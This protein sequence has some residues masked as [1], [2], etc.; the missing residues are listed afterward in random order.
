MGHITYGDT[1]SIVELVYYLPLL[2]ATLFVAWKHRATSF[3]WFI[4]VSF[5]LIRI[6][7]ACARIDTIDHPDSDTA[8]TMAFI[9]SIFGL[10]PLLMAT[11]G[12]LSR[13]FYQV[14]AEPWNKIYGGHA[15]TLLVHIPAMVAVVLCIVGATQVHEA[16]DIPNQ[17]TVKAGIVIFAVVFVLVAGFSVLAWV[18]KINTGEGEG[19]LIGAVLLTVPFLAVRLLYSL[20]SV[21]DSGSSTFNL[22][23]GSQTA[24]LCMAVL[25]EMLVVAILVAAG[26]KLSQQ[27]LRQQRYTG[28][29]ATQKR[30]L[31]AVHAQG[32]EGKPSDAVEQQC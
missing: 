25:E 5:C 1:I 31:D 21:F 14:R 3:A 9:C 18:A 24:A 6:I 8:Y 10:S 29:G 27:V 13:A 23:H 4:L 26:L 15:M 7:G 2:G 30:T 16:A 12:V 17:T 11:L 32:D 22:S 19:L 20:L 28:R